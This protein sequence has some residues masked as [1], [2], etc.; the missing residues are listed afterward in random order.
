MSQQKEVKA[1]V[2][3]YA[4]MK[5]HQQQKEFKCIGIFE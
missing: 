5:T 1:N 2:I 4:A 3:G